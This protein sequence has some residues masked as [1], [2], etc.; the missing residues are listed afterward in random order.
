MG[1]TDFFSQ[2]GAGRRVCLGK[3][4]GIFEVK[5]ILAFLIMRYDVSQ[6]RIVILTHEK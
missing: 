3:N 1:S 6:L 2:F 5:K 4:I